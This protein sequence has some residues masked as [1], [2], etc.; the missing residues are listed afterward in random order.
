VNWSLYGK[1]LDSLCFF[2]CEKC[3]LI[4]K[5]PQLQLAPERERARYET[6]QNNPDDPAYLRFLNRLA[7]PL[8]EKVGKTQVGLDFGCGPTS[9]MAGIFESTGRPC[10]SYDPFFFNDRSLLEQRYDF[11]SCSEA[12]EHFHHPAEEFM[13]LFSCLKPGGWLGVMTQPV[14]PDFAAWWYHRDPTHVSFY[15]P[16]T[17]AWIAKTYRATAVPIG[18]DVVLFQQSETN[19]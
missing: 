6:H 1:A 10:V 7:A 14:P 11:I 2:R 5:D 18:S 3:A 15:S 19:E 16:E 9:A 13:R 12:A 4:F 17:F 8:M